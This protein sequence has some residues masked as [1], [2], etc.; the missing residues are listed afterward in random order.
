[1]LKGAQGR[2]L[3]LPVLRGLVESRR[4]CAAGYQYRKG[5]YSNGRERTKFAE[6][7]LAG[8][9]EILNTKALECG[10]QNFMLGIFD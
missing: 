5:Q 2:G 6:A 4:S 9:L 10:S 7:H 8:D 1:M 3:L